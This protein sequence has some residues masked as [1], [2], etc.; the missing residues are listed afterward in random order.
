MQDKQVIVACYN[1]VGVSGKGKLQEAVVPAITPVAHG[2]CGFNPDRTAD[3][4]FQDACG[5]LGRDVAAE[6][7]PSK[8][9]ADFLLYGPGEANR[10]MRAGVQQGT[11][12]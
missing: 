5:P 1:R 3:D 11:Q 6:S 12:R 9:G 10:G 4:E 7:R 2:D 8:D